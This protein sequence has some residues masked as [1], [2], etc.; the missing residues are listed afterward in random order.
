MC[1][2]CP[3]IGPVRTRLCRVQARPGPGEGSGAALL[4]FWPERWS[5][6][7]SCRALAITAAAPGTDAGGEGVDG[8]A[9]IG[10]LV[11]PVPA[12]GADAAPSADE[13]GAAEQIGPDL[14]TVKVVFVAIGADADEGGGFRE[15]RELDGS[16]PGEGGLAAFGHGV[17]GSVTRTGGKYQAES[18]GMLDSGV[19]RGRGGRLGARACYTIIHGVTGYAERR[20]LPPLAPFARAAAALAGEVARPACCAR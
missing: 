1:S 15:E 13:E 9:R 14:K 20:G 19:L 10:M 7:W 6:T 12:G 16:G 11:K 17:A 4:I 18:S 2:P 3:S 5:A 8:G